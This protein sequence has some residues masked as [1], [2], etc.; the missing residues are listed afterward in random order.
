MEWFGQNWD[1]AS[2][3]ILGPSIPKGNSARGKITKSRWKLEVA[4]FCL[5]THT[6]CWTDLHPDSLSNCALCYIWFQKRYIEGGQRQ[7]HCLRRLMMQTC[8]W[9]YNNCAGKIKHNILLHVQS[10]ST[11]PKQCRYKCCFH[12]QPSGEKK[13]SSCLGWQLCLLNCTEEPM[14]N[15]TKLPNRSDCLSTTYLPLAFSLW[16]NDFIDTRS[17]HWVDK[18]LQNLL[19]SCHSREHKAYKEKQKIEHGEHDVAP[20]T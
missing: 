15:L 14:L 2:H 16:R 11:S 13:T 7:L 9:M 12:S 20:I 18:I 6:L 17:L 1:I 3:I 4:T 10:K 19:P 8:S 5:S